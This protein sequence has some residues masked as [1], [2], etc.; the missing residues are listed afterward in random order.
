MS[1]G[2]GFTGMAVNVSAVHKIVWFAH[3]TMGVNCAMYAIQ[4]TDWTPRMY[5]KRV[6]RVAMDV[7]QQMRRITYGV[8]L[9]INAK[10]VTCQ[11]TIKQQR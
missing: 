1:V 3:Y 8:V 7:T 6:Q 10:R 11:C 5:A 9:E 4:D 2:M